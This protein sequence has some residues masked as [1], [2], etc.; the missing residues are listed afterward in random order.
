MVITAD[1]PFHSAP[2]ISRERFARVMQ[3]VGSPWAGK[4][5]ALYD[6]IVGEGDDPAVWLAIGLREHRLLTDPIA[7]ALRLMTHSWT[8]ARSVRLPNL[9][10]EVVST[11]DLR[12]AGLLSRNGPYIR[13]RSVEDSLRDG[14]WRVRDPNYEYYRRFGARPTI[15]QVLSVWTESDA[16]NYTAFVVAKLNEWYEEAP[17]SDVELIPCLIP[18]GRNNRPGLP[19]VPRYITIHE[20]ANTAVGAHAE[21]HCRYIRGN[22]AASRPASWHVTV[23]DHSAYQH[24]PTNEVAWHAGDGSNGTG[25]RQSLAIELCVNADGDWER[26]MRNAASIVRRWMR[27]FEIP[28]K[29]VVQHGHWNKSTSCPARLRAGDW[30]RF[31]ALLRA[32]PT[33]PKAPTL[34]PTRRD[35]WGTQFWIPE[36]FIEEIKRH[37]WMITGYCKSEAFIE[38]G[39]IVQYFERAR[40]EI[41]PDG[42]VTRGLV[43]TEAMVARYPERA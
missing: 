18:A 26:T 23:D 16:A 25:N 1:S 11:D 14:I 29:R 19:L 9:D 43:G 3:D 20:T 40:L 10:Y 21:M 42:S 33:P 12:K 6:L 39:K 30:G 38:D 13:Y 2:R 15:G 8:N 34:P 22:E 27:D 32:E 17:V 41:Q 24:I 35:P 37:D 31:V 5:G 7:V 28:L 36:P 4:A